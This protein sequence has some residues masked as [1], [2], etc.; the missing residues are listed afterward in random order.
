MQKLMSVAS[1]ESIRQS[2]A[3][4]DG[5]DTLAIHPHAIY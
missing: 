2:S 5:E 4:G 3:S 1:A